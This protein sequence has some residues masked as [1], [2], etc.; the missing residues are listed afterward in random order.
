[1]VTEI[2]ATPYQATVPPTSSKR[3]TPRSFRSRSPSG[4][5]ALSGALSAGITI[6]LGGTFL[7]F[8]AAQAG[9]AILSRSRRRRRALGAASYG[10]EQDP[11][12]ETPAAAG[13]RADGRSGRRPGRRGTLSGLARVGGQLVAWFRESVTARSAKSTGETRH[14]WVIAYSN[15]PCEG[16]DGLWIEGEKIQLA[17]P[18]SLDGGR[19][20]AVF[21]RAMT[22]YQD[23]RWPGNIHI[24]DFPD[25]RGWFP[26]SK[27]GGEGATFKRLD[28]LPGDSWTAAHKLEGIAFAHV[29]LVNPNLWFQEASSVTPFPKAAET[30]ISGPGAENHLAGAG[31]SDVDE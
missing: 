16:I 4:S 22:D 21:P 14:H 10:A 20:R 11:G 29:T 5:G 1:M 30:G 3:S 6:A 19:V 26:H 24:Y 8:T 12:T 18:V 7:G 25:G 27:V 23:R 31:D 15:G 17:A 13:S 28:E 2:P 9:L